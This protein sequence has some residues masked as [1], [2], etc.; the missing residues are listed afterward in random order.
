MNNQADV[1]Y[2]C[3]KWFSCLYFRKPSDSFYDPDQVKRCPRED[4]KHMPIV[5]AMPILFINLQPVVY[6]NVCV[7][8][9]MNSDS[10]LPSAWCWCLN[11]K[12][13]RANTALVYFPIGVI[14]EVEPS[15][16]RSV[17]PTGMRKPSARP[18]S[19]PSLHYLSIRTYSAYP[20]TISDKQEKWTRV[21]VP[22]PLR[23]F[24]RHFCKSQEGGV[25]GFVD[26][27]SNA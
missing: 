16:R 2:S 18:L 22:Y 6:V 23:K 25:S 4:D 19:G 5:T 24:R 12:P 1:S 20:H 11:Y 14:Q 10:S 8:T 15:I 21:W 27:L 7:L 3:L 17:L 26:I 13:L 9:V